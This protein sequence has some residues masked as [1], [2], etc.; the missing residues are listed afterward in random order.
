MNT[1][2]W[3]DRC[4]SWETAVLEHCLCNSLVTIKAWPSPWTH[5]R[6]LVVEADQATTPLYKE[7]AGIVVD[8]KAMKVVSYAWPN[9]EPDTPAR[10][11]ELDAECTCDVRE[12][13][14]GVAM[15]YTCLVNERGEKEWV[16]ST[17]KYLLAHERRW[18]ADRSFGQ[19][20]DEVWGSGTMLDEGYTHRFTLLHPDARHVVPICRPE[21][22]YTGSRRMSD[23]AI[24]WLVAMPTPT[25]KTGSLR[26]IL[27][28]ME[29]HGWMNAGVQFYDARADRLLHILNPDFQYVAELKGNTVHMIQ[30][31]LH[32]ICTNGEVAAFLQFFPEYLALAEHLGLFVQLLGLELWSRSDEFA[33]W[34]RTKNR[35]KLPSP[36]Y[37][38]FLAASRGAALTM[39]MAY[40]V[41]RYEMKL[42]FPDF[43]ER[44]AFWNQGLQIPSVPACHT[45]L[46]SFE[47]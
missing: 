18:L 20:F 14:D 13:D 40:D 43:N 3:L 47:K 26:D 33:R 21:I 9:V 11:M 16:L 41:W 23:F 7:W 1:Q 27:K 30:H 6:M 25:P 44:M 19:L 37:Q 46:E 28:Q 17:E 36:W 42:R 39:A 5:L 22:L 35:P 34:Q 12:L 4:G 31:V 32:L 15:R 8:T 38:A 45:G 10:R 2:A 29:S 24:E